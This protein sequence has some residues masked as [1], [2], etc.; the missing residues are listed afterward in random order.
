MVSLQPLKSV[1][2][3]SLFGT[4]RGRRLVLNNPRGDEG[5]RLPFDLLVDS[6][7]LLVREREFP[8]LAKSSLEKAVILDA[9][10]AS[11]FQNDKIHVAFRVVEKTGN[12]LLVRQYIIRETD[13]IRIR[14]KFA[15]Q[16]QKI[17]TV[18]PKDAP[19]AR[20][21]DYTTELMAPTAHWRK[22][23]MLMLVPLMFLVGA[24]A[25][26]PLLQFQ[27][28]RD[29][30]AAHVAELQAEAKRL[31]TF[32]A[33]TADRSSGLRQ[34]TERHAQNAD[35]LAVVDKLTA[36]LPDNAW[37]SL[38]RFDG[39]TLFV[40]GNTTGDVLTLLDE[41]RKAPGFGEPLVQSSFSVNGSSNEL[42]FEIEVPV[43]GG[44]P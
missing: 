19:N 17:R 4:P 22:L 42:R 12:T 30:A 2:T 8:A 35:V 28:E 44:K 1:L 5:T 20:L 31:K 23:N 26:V 14:E 10:R 43:L 16:G 25:Y 32:L 15:A 9:K 40:S 36:A 34:A 18:A 37:V 24:N 29:T 33:D 39:E 21:A 11:P 38:L 13:L 41:I 6:E 3:L 7:A 27:Q